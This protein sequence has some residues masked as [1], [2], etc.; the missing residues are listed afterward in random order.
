[1]DSIKLTLFLF[2]SLQ[3]GFVFSQS[4]FFDMGEHSGF[5]R[6]TD[7]HYVKVSSN[8]S[9]RSL[10]SNT[11]LAVVEK[12]VLQTSKGAFEVTLNRAAAV[13]LSRVGKSVRALA[14]L[15]G[16]VGLTLTAASLVCE[17]TTIC[18]QAGEWF[19][20]GDPAYPGYPASSAYGKYI[21]GSHVPSGAPSAETSCAR[22]MTVNSFPT[23]WTSELTS[24]TNCRIKNDSGAT[25][26]D[27]FVSFQSGSCA[28][29]YAYDASSNSCLATFTQSGVATAANWTAKE[30]LLNDDRFVPELFS[31]GL[32]IPVSTPTFSGSS[33]VISSMGSTTKTLKDGAGNV[34][35]TEVTTDILTVTDAATPE[36]PNRM[37]VTQST[38]TNTYNTSNVLT[39]STT[40]V[41]EPL[42]PPPKT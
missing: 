27:L 6:G 25:S 35:G 4:V 18:E 24:P 20:S 13:D 36:N 2:L 17:L 11:A 5:V 22:Y 29:G 14:L 26:S 23:G 28:T 37:S 7:G 33:P 39:G 10:T 31:Q 3:S 9:V 8:G 32:S 15:G 38:I 30:S 12:P 19:I 21:T 16:P 1:M 40:T 41:T 34:T 42:Q